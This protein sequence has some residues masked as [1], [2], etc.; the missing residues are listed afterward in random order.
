M[1][2]THQGRGRL[3]QRRDPLRRDDPPEGGRRHAARRSCSRPGDHPRHQGRRRR[4][5]ARVRRGRDR[6]P[7][8]STGCASGSPSTASSAR[9]SP[10]GAR[11][12]S[13]TDDGSRR[14]YCIDV[15]AHALARYAALCQEA[16]IVPI[17]EPEVLMD[18]D[19]TI[20]RCFER[21][22]ATRCDA[23][24]DA[25]VRAA[26]RARG[27]A[28]QAEHGALGLRSAPAAG[29][30][31]RGRGGDDRGASATVPP[32]CPASCSCPAASPTSRP[33]RTST[34]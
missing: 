28:A 4:E 23:V 11:R 30:R 32:R 13:I 25:L 2:F 9:G 18:G 17:V 26:R 6:S 24:F 15:N 29:V 16:G 20:E 8:A 31:R 19:H 27:H 7:R 3:H 33:P 12:T 10:S 22:H 21:H 14:Q 5:A 1:L 34:R